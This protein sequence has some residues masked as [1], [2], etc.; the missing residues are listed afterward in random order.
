MGEHNCRLIE[1]KHMDRHRIVS[2][3]VLGVPFLV[4]L[5]FL[6]YPVFNVLLR[7]ITYGPGSTLIEVLSVEITY[8]ILSF[9]MYQA[10][11]SAIFTVL[12]GLPGAFLLTR[13]RF[14]GKSIL[15]AALVVP[16]ILPP[17]VVV[18]GFL[19]MFGPY[20]IIDSL[21][22]SL[23][24][25]T[26]SV[27]DLS[28]GLTGIL[29]AH[30]FYN[31]PLVLLLVSSALERLDP[32]IEESA[33]ILGASSFQ[34]LRYIIL[35]RILPSI[36]AAAIL[37]FLFCFMSFPIVLSLGKGRLNTLEVQIWE[38]YRFSDFG[39]AS[40][41]GLIQIFI[42]LALAF[43]YIRISKTDKDTSGKTTFAKTFSFSALSR[44]V[45][46]A[47]IVYF[48][49]IL[50]LVAGPFISI[51][52]AAF[53]D[54][55]NNQLT[56]KGFSNLFSFE[57]TGSGNAFINTIF[58][59]STATLLSVVF[60]IPLAYAHTSRKKATANFASIL[61]LLP[62]GVSSITV[63]Y[64]LMLVIAVPLGLTT[65]PWPLIVI[66]QTIIGL[67]FT[68]R[69]VEISLRNLDSNLLEQADLLGTSRFERFFFIELPLLAPGILVGAVFA[70]AMAIGEMSATLFIALP[71]NITLT[72]AI[73]RHLNVRRFVEAGA[74]SLVLIIMCLI[75]F[76]IIEQISESTAGVAL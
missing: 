54:P 56:L 30:V 71:E 41:L 68:T 27:F 63:A 59:S 45:R 14:K 51:F 15:R 69:A 61:T 6:M 53:Y 36:L 16:F 24:N 34:K 35:P 44:E 38:A 55:I 42:S 28:S 32:D 58:Y 22:M 3:V 29:L 1:V 33:E 7:G 52:R 43:S 20:G 72:V 64:G 26:K 50:V 76:I 67:P 60:G 10:F 25:S 47:I 8:R 57:S 66:A 2:Q 73:Y 74:A 11:L 19:H 37:T 46:L 75:S 9:T 62:L 48:S 5:F 18:A 21:L 17:I 4:L 65:N 12:L 39:E 13:F 49:T 31:V 70:F 40:T 23:A